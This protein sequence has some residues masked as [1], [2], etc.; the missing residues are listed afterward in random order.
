MTAFLAPTAH[1]HSQ[2]G[3]PRYL[4]AVGKVLGTVT[5]ICQI[6]KAGAGVGNAHNH[7][8]PS[9]ELWA[10]DMSGVPAAFLDAPARAPLSTAAGVHG[11][12]S[13]SY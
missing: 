10:Y 12:L 1:P 5:A 3:S 8:R 7:K 6:R 4:G 2:E 9:K 13:R 11:G